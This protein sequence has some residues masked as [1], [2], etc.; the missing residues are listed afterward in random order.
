FRA[1]NVS[2]DAKATAAGHVADLRGPARTADEAANKQSAMDVFKEGQEHY[3][4]ERWAAAYDK[5]TI[6]YDISSDPAY[7]FNRAQA[8]RLVGGRREEAIALY[9]EFMKL[10][11]GPEAKLQARTR[12]AE[13][14]IPGGSSGQPGPNAVGA[15]TQGQV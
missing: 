14:R 7:M 11:V 12:L 1:L 2:E 5:F 9:E 15:P 6:A 8:L 13:L 3:A 4:A 10:N